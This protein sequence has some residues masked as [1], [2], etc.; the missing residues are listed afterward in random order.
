MKRLGLSRVTTYLALAAAAVALLIFV[1]SYEFPREPLPTDKPYIED[2]LTPDEV[3]GNRDCLFQAGFGNAAGMGLVVLPRNNSYA[4]EVL[5]GDGRL[6][7]D[8]L[9]FKPNHYRL[10]KDRN[11]SILAGFADLR[12]NSLVYRDEHTREPIQVFQDGNL[13]YEADKVWNFG[14][15]PDGSAFFVIEPTG[16]S[17][18][19]LLIYDLEEGTQHQQDLGYEYTSRYSELPYSA[20]FSV[21][22]DEVVLAPS[23]NGGG[24]SHHFYPVDGSAPRKIRLQGVGN[25]VFES[26]NHGYFV[27]GQGDGQPLL[28]QKKEFRWNAALAEPKSVDVWT[29]E[30]G[31]EH[32]YGNISLSNDG[33]WLLLGAWDL[34]VLDSNTG[35]TVF[36]FPTAT[37]YEEAQFARISNVMQRGATFQ[38]IG[39]VGHVEILDSE[40]LM[41]RTLGNPGSAASEHFI[42]VFDMATIQLDSK[43]IFRVQVDPN[44]RCQAGDF[45][46]RGLQVEGDALTYLT[47]KRSANES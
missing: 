24:D 11:G 1:L 47:K 30:I 15:A 20:R 18:S 4:F 45:S 13:I 7:G 44:N 34:H 9:P 41:H 27:F 5:D 17:T 2:S 3:I 46:L 28:I 35:E 19:Q 31:L 14:L 29:R 42:D 12:L 32:F 26:M 6:F 43:P 25:L 36:T 22:S 16:G 21:T 39:G 40:L 23:P 37:P 33:A 8:V 10:A 38:D